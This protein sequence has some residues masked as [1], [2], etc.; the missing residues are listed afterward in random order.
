MTPERDEEVHRHQH[1]LPEEE[2][3]EH[4][5]RQEDADDAAQNPHQVEM[6]KA[7]ILLDFVPGTEHRHQAEQAGQHHHQQRQ[8]IQRQMEINAEARDP[9]GGELR[10][11]LR[12]ARRLRQ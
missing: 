5:D 8:A 1:H 10:L 7:L 3:Q 9:G 12:H 6:E 11:P 2:E 4:I